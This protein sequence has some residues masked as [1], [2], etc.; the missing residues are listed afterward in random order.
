MTSGVMHRAAGA[1][2]R[3]RDHFTSSAVV[4]MYHRIAEPEVDP[5]EMAVSPRHFE[6]H[7]Q[8]LR[9]E[10]RPVPL[11]KLATDLHGGS[12]QDRG[13]VLTFDDGYLDNLTVALPL[14]ARYEIP[15]TIFCTTRQL[16]EG[17]KSPI[18]WER[19]ERA[20]LLPPKLPDLLE[21][22]LR[23]DTGTWRLDRAAEYTEEDR[24]RDRGVRPWQ[25]APG[26]RLHFYYDLYETLRVLSAADRDGMLGDLEEWAG[27]SGDAGR[28]EMI[29]PERI[30]T[31]S[32]DG[33]IEVGAHTVTHP[34]LSALSPEKQENEIVRSRLHLEELVGRAVTSFAYPHGDVTAKAIAT[35]RIHFDTACDIHPQPVTRWSDPFQLPRFQVPD[36]DGDQLASLFRRGQNGR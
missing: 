35:A 32:A 14:L 27:M 16:E 28:A 31:I 7:L 9:A 36:C 34:F 21:L 3:L 1:V 5:W 4:L 18:W 24:R 2:R 22:R 10:T 33:L 6:E 13:V 23:A 12:V 20:T 26:T 8:V 30:A 19:L 11:S 15:A 25:A 29:P 17:G